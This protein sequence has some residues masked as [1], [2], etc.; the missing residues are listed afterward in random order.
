MDICQLSCPL[1][2]FV[3]GYAD[4]V[5]YATLGPPELLFEDLNAMEDDATGNPNNTY[6]KREGRE[7]GAPPSR[8]PLDTD[9]D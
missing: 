9:A 4:A 7:K 8:S 1:V 2:S 5:Q 3:R 6:S